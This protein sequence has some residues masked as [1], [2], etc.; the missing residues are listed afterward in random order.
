MMSEVSR[1]FVKALYSM[2]HVVRLVPPDH[3]DDPSPCEGWTARHVLGHVIAMQAYYTACIDGRPPTMDPMV[4][5]DR[6]AGAD[7]A[8][9]W[10]G[11][12]DGVLEA[13][14]RPQVLTSVVAALD[15]DQRVE[16]LIAMNVLDTTVHS[17]DLARACGVDDRL[18][19]GLVRRSMLLTGRLRRAAR[20]AGAFAP[21]VRD[22]APG[23]QAALLA[24]VGRRA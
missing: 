8:Q 4:D 17:W 3:W 12:R 5:P 11:A 21:A 14:D 18:D 22:H 9:S 24:A 7:P 20:D 10:C 13:I 16:D 23:E 15:G 19:P 2:D 1:W 6:H